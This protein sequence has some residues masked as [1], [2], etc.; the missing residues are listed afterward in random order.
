MVNSINNV[1]SI[2][3][4][5]RIGLFS[6][7]LIGLCSEAH[8]QVVGAGSSY[9]SN[10]GA[11][12]GSIP[13]PPVVIHN[14]LFAGSRSGEGLESS[15]RSNPIAFKPH[16]NT[17]FAG[18]R[19]GEGVGDANRS[20]P[21]A[22][23]PHQK[24]SFVGSRSGEG[25]GDLNRSSPIS[26]TSVKNT[27]F[28][29]SRSGEPVASNL[30]KN[31]PIVITPGHVIMDK[32]DYARKMTHTGTAAHNGL[33]AIVAP[34]AVQA[35]LITA[36]ISK[37]TSP[38]G[39]K[40]AVDL[41]GD[42]LISFSVNEK[43]AREL[44]G[45]SQYSPNGTVQISTDMAKQI[46]SD[47]VNMSGYRKGDRV[48][49]A[50]GGAIVISDGTH[51]DHFASN[52]LV[53]QVPSSRGSTGSSRNIDELLT[54][55]VAQTQSSEASTMATLLQARN[56]MAVDQSVLNPVIMQYQSNEDNAAD[57]LKAALNAV[58][59][60]SAN[61]TLLSDLA[62]Q[63][64][65]AAA[66]AANNLQQAR[67]LLGANQPASAQLAAL[68]AQSQAYT[69][70][71]LAGLRQAQTHVSTSNPA[72]NTITSV[73]AQSQASSATIANSLVQARSAVAINQ[74]VS[75]QLTVAFN[76]YQIS[77]NAAAATLS[78]VQGEIR[79]GQASGSPS[80]VA[81]ISQY[82]AEAASA[83]N[84]LFQAR[85]LV[86]ANQLASNDL[87]EALNLYQVNE[88]TV[89]NAL[90]QENSATGNLGVFYPAAITEPPM[91]P[92]TITMT[93]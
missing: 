54:T 58:E 40:W 51:G 25:T 14:A 56:G 75:G 87:T 73:V 15:N 52:Q 26:L 81:L 31:K 9:S 6:A 62:R 24:T 71:I 28:A 41:Y 1:H 13:A 69:A 32:G 42:H 65:M 30:A 47:N 78:A 48:T 29:G 72:A 43:T 8:A 16:Q 83:T 79:N 84:A 23:T 45:V 35:D 88:N 37:I 64:Q 89:M 10:N 59:S 34:N 53:K 91:T 20:S 18:S 77:A 3:A 57:N 12:T 92:Q 44:F 86:G 36:N 60:G 49:N 7:A 27:L 76:Q 19:S 68:S 38:S 21:I 67:S 4:L 46:I 85:Q 70:S 66:N 93:Y 11:P 80:L 90:T 63:Y 5:A 50:N 2:K 82:Q 33:G 22:L 17:S 61:S 55:Y 39:N 74:S